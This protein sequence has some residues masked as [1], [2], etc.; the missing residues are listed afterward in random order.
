M[1]DLYKL[2]VEGAQFSNFCGGAGG[3]SPHESCM[4]VASIPGVADGFVLRDTKPEGAG[5]EV[6]MTGS[7][8]DDFAVGWAQKRGLAL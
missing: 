8:L 1:S 3:T 4:D 2:D 6:R 7:E 5:H